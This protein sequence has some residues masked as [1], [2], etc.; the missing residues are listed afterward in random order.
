[1]DIFGPN[2]MVYYGDPQFMDYSINMHQFND[3]KTVIHSFVTTDIDSDIFSHGFY[4]AMLCQAGRS[5]RI[6]MGKAAA[7]CEMH[8]LWRLALGLLKETPRVEEFA[9][10]FR[11]FVNLYALY[12]PKTLY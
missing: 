2:I 11:C 4:G 6:I 1:M 10:G 3:Y 7:C 12:L 5:L 8:G 9:C